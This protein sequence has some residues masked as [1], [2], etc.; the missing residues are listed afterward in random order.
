M[1]VRALFTSILGVLVT[2]A[3]GA[4]AASWEDKLQKIYPAAKAEG[5]V[6]F[7]SRRIS[8]V[9]GKKGV[10]QF[11]KRFPGIDIVFTGISGSKL[12]ARVMLEAKAGRISVDAFRAGP[13]R[14]RALA[15]KGLLLQVDPAAITDSPVKTFFGNRFF[16]VSDHITNFAYN[17][18]LLKPADRP[19]TYEDLLKPKFKRRLILDARGGQISHLLSEKIWD[20]GKF[21]TFVKGLKAHKP[22][23]TARNSTAMAKLT[24][25]EGMI[26][27]ASYVAIQTLKKKGAPVE[28][29][30]LSPSLS[31]VR[32]IGIIKGSPHPNAAKLLLGWL[33]SPEGLKARDRYAVST[34]TPGTKLYDRVKASG[35]K[36]VIEED[37]KQI[38]ARGA[39]G[40]KIT[41]DWG[42]LSKLKKKRK[43]KKKK[44]KKK[45]S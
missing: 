42:V 40:D 23:W 39:V 27:T 5:K 14:A 36:I 10:A 26:S 34:I 33:L 13:D 44:K 15:D 31:Q 38:R 11:K 17:T 7:N 43:K 22:V 45:S 28:F 32:A 30:F 4:G 1:L 24:S 18:D 29:L 2:L 35:A 9:G 19:K 16:K 8:E 37:I 3:S 12:P 21:W 6:I 25:G 20:E 41:T